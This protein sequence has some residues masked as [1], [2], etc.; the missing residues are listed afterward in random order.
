M[1]QRLIHEDFDEL[2]TL[3]GWRDPLI[4]PATTDLYYDASGNHDLQDLLY[5]VGDSLPVEIHFTPPPPEVTEPCLVIREEVQ[6]NDHFGLNHQPRP[7][8]I[9]LLTPDGN[10]IPQTLIWRRA[11]DEQDELQKTIIEFA[12]Q[13]MEI[14]QTR[15]YD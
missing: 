3:K 4:K 8:T 1:T 12:N 9:S 15:Q 11:L 10:E 2:G 6:P 7:L 5:I 13:A 14:N